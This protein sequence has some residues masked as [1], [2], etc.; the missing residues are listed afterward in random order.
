M[1]ERARKAQGISSDSSRRL[2]FYQVHAAE[3]GSKYYQN[4]CKSAQE[5][6]TVSLYSKNDIN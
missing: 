4:F 1:C 6:C 5:K 2:F 3:H